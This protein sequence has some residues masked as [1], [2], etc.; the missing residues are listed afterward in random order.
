MT[1]AA[2]RRILS[3]AVQA[4]P[5]AQFERGPAQMLS[6][7]IGASFS[8]GKD[9]AGRAY[10]D[11]ISTLAQSNPR[12]AA[13]V[14]TL[15]PA[16]ADYVL[17]NTVGKVVGGGA[18]GVYGYATA[19]EDLGAFDEER[20]QRAIDY[21]LLGGTAGHFTGGIGLPVVKHGPGLAKRMLNP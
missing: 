13:L 20:I 5:E 7:Q 1:A 8:A 4:R 2:V 12:L 9:E 3:R 14:E 11:L 16:A 18:G 21:M 15:P 10:A 19:D 17:G 6:E